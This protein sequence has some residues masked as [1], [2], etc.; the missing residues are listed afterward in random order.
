MIVWVLERLGIGNSDVH[1]DKLP[2]HTIRLNVAPEITESGKMFTTT[3]PY[4]SIRDDASVRGFALGWIRHAIAG[5]TNVVVSCAAGVNRSPT[6][7]I[8][9]LM[10]CGMSKSEAYG[11]VRARHPAAVPFL[12]DVHEVERNNEVKRT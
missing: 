8:M 4:S 9:Y 5:G 10:D 6:I 7:V 11:F 12:E 1:L 2:P 3:L